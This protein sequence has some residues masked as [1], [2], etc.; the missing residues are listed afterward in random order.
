MDLMMRAIGGVPCAW[1]HRDPESLTAVPHDGLIFSFQSA[2]SYD[3]GKILKS[4]TE[5]AEFR[6]RDLHV[7]DREAE[8]QIA[9]GKRTQGAG[10]GR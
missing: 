6:H 5:G 1:P 8:I 9:A 4:G 10:R 7:F 2:V 3:F